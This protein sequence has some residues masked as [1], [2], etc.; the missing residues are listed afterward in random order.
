M[1]FTHSSNVQTKYDLCSS[2][3]QEIRDSSLL[4]SFRIG[5]QSSR[6]MILHHVLNGGWSRI[7]RWIGQGEIEGNLLQ[8]GLPWSLWPTPT[9]LGLKCAPN[10]LLSQIRH[11]PTL[12]DFYNFSSMPCLFS[13]GFSCTIFQ[14]VLMWVIATYWPLHDCMTGNWE[15]NFWWIDR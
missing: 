3:R 12:I 14:V 15:E 8:M 2:W 10:E 11:W 13:Q 4:A 5:W 1:Y 9:S 7:F 6:L